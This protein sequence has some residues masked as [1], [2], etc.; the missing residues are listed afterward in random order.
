VSCCCPALLQ[1]VILVQVLSHEINHGYKYTVTP[2]HSFNST[3]VSHSLGG[4]HSGG[5]RGLACD[6]RP[7]HAVLQPCGCNPVAATLWL[8]ALP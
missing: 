2:C 4:V 6:G 5:T 1:I 3:K 7:Q 8:Q